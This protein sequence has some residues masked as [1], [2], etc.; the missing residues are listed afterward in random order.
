MLPG[1]GDQ[2]RLLGRAADEDSTEA[3]VPAR[4]SPACWKLDQSTAPGLRPALLCAYLAMAVFAGLAANSLLGAWWLDGLV[5]LGISAWAVVEGRRAWG[6]DI[7]SAA[8][9][10]Q[11]RRAEHSQ[12][13]RAGR[14]D[15]LAR[16]SDRLGRDRR[17]P[18]RDR[19]RCSL[20][21]PAG[22]GR[23]TCTRSGVPARQD[24]R[25]SFWPG[26]GS[27]FTSAR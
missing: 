14:S 4:P 3:A 20:P 10:S 21:R 13:T 27:Y 12:I 11:R 9:P 22:D 16:C 25:E 6:R 8:Q 7:C 24:C 5:A 15:N 17:R 1:D 23:A 18:A 19:N 2:V 26:S